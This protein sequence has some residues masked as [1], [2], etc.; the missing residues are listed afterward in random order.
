VVITPRLQYA[1]LGKED[2][3][4]KLGENVVVCNFFVEYRI[5]AVV[6]TDSNTFHT[7]CIFVQILFSIVL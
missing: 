5:V 6:N 7:T 2:V 4:T 1:K 3:L